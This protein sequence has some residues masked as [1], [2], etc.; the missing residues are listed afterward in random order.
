[1]NKL[2]GNAVVFETNPH[3]VIDII[4]KSAFYNCFEVF[5]KDVNL[6][7][8]PSYYV[9]RVIDYSRDR[10]V[11]FFE[12]YM[13]VNINDEHMDLLKTIEYIKILIYYSSKDKATKIN[14][15][16]NLTCK[17]GFGQEKINDLFVS[18]EQKDGL[19]HFLGYLVFLYVTTKI[20]SILYFKN[21]KYKKTLDSMWLLID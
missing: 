2:D 12:N 21:K 20:N 9:D 19:L 3:R 7:L 15:L 18:F 10:L 5:H 13:F 16:K 17:K 11:P 1:M 14:N 6:L 8:W 4:Q